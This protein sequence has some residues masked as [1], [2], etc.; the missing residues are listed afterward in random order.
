MVINVKI[1]TVLMMPSVK[2]LV[3]NIVRMLLVLFVRK[4]NLLAF[5]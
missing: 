1:S 2:R 5:Y 4:D 3:I